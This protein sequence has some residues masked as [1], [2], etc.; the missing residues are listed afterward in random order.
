[1]KAE[2]VGPSG[3]SSKGVTELK[4]DP[5]MGPP[6]MPQLG[7]CL[8]GESHQLWDSQPQLRLVHP[9]G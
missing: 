9:Y 7:H 3:L 8:A 4:H 1:M 6:A 2:P 5:Y